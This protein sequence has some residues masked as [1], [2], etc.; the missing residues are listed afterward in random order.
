M[1]PTN[2]MGMKTASSTTVVATIGEATLC[3]ASTAAARGDIPCSM[4]TCAASTTTMA[5]STT[6]P[7]AST[8]PSSE[9]M[10]IEKPSS[11]KKMNVP[12][13][14]TGMATSG[15]SVARQSWMKR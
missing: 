15:M 8:S 7:M 11:G 5:S 9:M 10:L 2:D 1:P 6:S 3:I 14:D 13:S 4:L 12:M